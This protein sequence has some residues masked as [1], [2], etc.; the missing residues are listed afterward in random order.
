MRLLDSFLKAESY[1]GASNEDNTD[2]AADDDT[3]NDIFES[4]LADIV[5]CENFINELKF[6]F[7]HDRI[8]GY[9]KE[10]ENIVCSIKTRFT[11]EEAVKRF[12]QPCVFKVEYGFEER[13]KFSEDLIDINFTDLYS[14][15]KKYLFDFMSF[16]K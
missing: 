16:E 5:L 13:G 15:R 12:H 14:Y 6:G 2:A 8:Y 7:I 11:L 3:S 1:K 9:G 10:S 4:D